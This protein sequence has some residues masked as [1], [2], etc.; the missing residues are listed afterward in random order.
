MN[1]IPFEYGSIAENEYF[2][3]RVED[4]RD[5]KTFLGGGINV[6]LISPRRWGKSSLVKAAMEELKQEDSHVRVCYLDAFKI[7]TEEDFYNQFASAVIQGVS[8]NLEKRWAD[9]V[10]FVQ[11]I[12]PSLTVNSDPVNAVEVKLGFKPLKESAEEILNLPEKMATAKGI[13]VIVCIDEFQQL[14]NLPDWKRLEGTMRSV[15]QAQ[16]HT[17]YCLYGS[18]RHMM[19]EIFGNS[20]NPFYRFGQMMTLKRI[21]KAYWMP[22]IHDSFYNFGK[23]I[24]DEMIDRICNVMQCHSWYM[25][26]FCFLIWTRTATDVTEEIYRSQLTKLLDTNSD[27]FLSDLDGIASSQIAF[28]RAVCMGETH[29]NAQQ[30]V[31]QYGLGAPRTITKNKKTLVEKDLI[32]KVGDGFKLVDPVFELWFKREYCNISPF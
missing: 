12:S 10:K 2:I 22:F 24:S 21:D 9:V 17:T 8:S 29:F 14:A 4:R 30:V 23:T 31:A 18:K 26:Q 28:L 7:F 16:Q 19:M 3:D 11:S 15:W 5:L 13:H 25:Q 27:M 20:N 6:M 1:K 32:E